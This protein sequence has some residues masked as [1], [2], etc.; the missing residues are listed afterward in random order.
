VDEMEFHFSTALLSRR[1]LQEL[2]QDFPAW[3]HAADGLRFTAFQGL[4]HG[5]IDLVFEHD[6][7][8]WLADYKSN[9][10]EDYGPA[11]LEE[12]MAEHHYPLQALIYSLALH[13]HLGQCLPDYDPA[14]NLGGVFY[15]FT[16][17]M[18]PDGDAGIWHRQVEPALLARFDEMLKGRAVA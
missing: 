2:L 10:L 9:R 17:G 14:R 18:R 16:R 11:G 5:F 1:N 7:R 8:Y 13:R 6:G 12:A 15:L 3:R 4:L